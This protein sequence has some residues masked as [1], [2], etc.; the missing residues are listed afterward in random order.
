M[1]MVGWV[2]IMGEAANHVDPAIQAAHPEVPW[3]EMVGMRN[4]ITHGY[5]QVDYDTLW[6]VLAVDVPALVE[7]VKAILAA[8]EADESTDEQ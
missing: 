1:A 2:E 8:L 7:P 4:H 5:F 3:R 6:N